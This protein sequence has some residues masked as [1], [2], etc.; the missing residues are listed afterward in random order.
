MGVS[1]SQ[2]RE[3]EPFVVSTNVIG[4]QSFV[5]VDTSYVTFSCERIALDDPARAVSRVR[6]SLGVLDV[7]G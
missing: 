1:V 6:L 3:A 4:Y 2:Q 7:K 5:W